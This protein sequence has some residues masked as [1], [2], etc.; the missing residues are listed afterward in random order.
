MKTWIWIFVFVIL[1][2]A[3]TGLVFS[4]Y[5]MFDSDG[6]QKSVS[7]SNQDSTKVD[8]FKEQTKKIGG[9]TY[10]LKLSQTPDESEIIEVMHHMTHQK[11]KAD[12][13]WGAK[14]MIPETINEIYEVVSKSDF[15]RK[16]DLLAIL[17]RW[18]NG[19]F[20]QADDDHNYFWDYQNGTVGAAYGIMSE[21]EEKR[22]I[23]NNF[24]EE[25]LPE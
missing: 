13:K 7:S 11:V 6:G 19:D 10:D 12:K 1:I 24:G 15:A 2:G 20:S 23:L 3:T 17:E 22:F 5:K 16:E 4:V 14:P 8:E 18:K 9:V 21:A 25:F